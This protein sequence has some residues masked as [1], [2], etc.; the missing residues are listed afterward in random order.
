MLFRQGDVLI[1]ATKSIPRDAA[2]LPHKTLAHGEVTGH[3]H[4]IEEAADV[5]LFE[6]NGTLYLRVRGQNATVVH[7][8]HGPVSVPP[9]GL[10]QGPP[11]LA[12]RV[13]S[14]SLT[15]PSTPRMREPEPSLSSGP[16]RKRLSWAPQKTLCRM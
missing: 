7:Q 9:S 12:S 13:I 11:K 15:R 14:S 5:E 6:L 10:A 4:R 2:K 1:M 8:E 3:S 16:P